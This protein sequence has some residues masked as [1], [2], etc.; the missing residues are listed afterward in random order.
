MELFVTSTMDD[1]GSGFDILYC[2]AFYNEK[3]RLEIYKN[4]RRIYTNFKTPDEAQ[5]ALSEILETKTKA[6]AATPFTDAE[7]RSFLQKY[8]HKFRFAKTY[9]SF[10][11]HEYCLKKFL[12]DEAKKGFERFVAKIKKEAVDTYYYK[13]CYKCMIFDGYFYWA[14]GREYEPEDIINRSTADHFEQVGDCYRRIVKK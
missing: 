8:N 10:D 2:V 14:M 5:E 7:L 13:R 6:D 1:A 9:A 3:G 4:D 11:P 12:D